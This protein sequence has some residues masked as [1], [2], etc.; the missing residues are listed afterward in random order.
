MNSYFN[1]ADWTVILLYLLGIISLGV[2]FGKDQHN[3][4]DYFLGSKNIPWWGIGL[5]IVAAETSA[6]TIISV[7]AIA[8]GSNIALLQMIIGYVIARIILAVVLVPHYF[9]GEIYSPYQLFANAFGPSARQTAAGFFLL[10]ETL[11]AGV[12]VYVA[13]IPV[14]LML[15]DKLLGFGTGDPILGAILLFVL[16]SLLYTYIGG[17]KAVI[18]TDAVQ[19]GLFLIGGI[20]ALFYIPSLAGGVSSAFAQASQAA[21]LHWLNALPPP[22]VAFS[23]FLLGS[24]FNIWMGIIG[25]TVVVMSSHGAEQLIV[26]RVLACKTVADGR[27]A[28]ALSAVVIF[29]LF[30][31]FL[32]VGA[33]LWVFYQ[34]HPF[35]IPLPEP[36]AGSGIK[37]N[38][39]VFPIFMMTEV[40]HILKGFLIVAILSAAMSSVS[41]AL[42][43]LASVST[44]DF[45][46]HLLP[47]RTEAF[48]L[49]FSKVSTVVWAVI[50]IFIAY[51]SR[52]V[53]FVLNAAFSLRGLTS[54]A[55]LGGLALAI[56]WKKGR[57]AS[58]ISGMMVSLAVMT[59][60]QVFPA[61]SV[62]REFWTRTIGTEIF[63]PWYT[64]IGL[65][66]TL[67]TALLVQRLLP[68]KS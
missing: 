33:L 16:L 59:A 2:W 32:L 35:K 7:P 29:P 6:L 63:W 31:V 51:L 37:A 23:K 48:F 38:D 12:R 14:K 15:G 13:S 54:G 67:T 62:T 24:P 3:T 10:S 66:V 45:V 50:L 27:K 26:Q 20:F 4:R 60:I 36:R 55:L 44:M 68:G 19:F 65:F 61:W 39:F 42:T 8:F 46:R 18:W 11:A 41:S 40:P 53:D 1:P 58:V 47:Q 21:K 25:G 34:S 5:S 52:Q 30:L 64:S 43:S 22:G 28:L 57:A 49:R 56:F 9:K 17:V